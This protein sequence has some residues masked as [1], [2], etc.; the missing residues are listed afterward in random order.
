VKVAICQRFHETGL[1]A[2][3]G[4]RSGGLAARGSWSDQDG[5]HYHCSGW[6]SATDVTRSTPL[7]LA[8]RVGRE[9]RMLP[10]DRR[11]LNVLDCSCV[12]GESPA[13]DPSRPLLTE[14]YPRR[15]IEDVASSFSN[16]SLQ[17]HTWSAPDGLATRRSW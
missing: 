2:G 13:H 16:I 4:P 11:R 3:A 1:L 15:R 7:A 9:R 10:A 17:F 14:R 8:I 6:T 5:G 12:H